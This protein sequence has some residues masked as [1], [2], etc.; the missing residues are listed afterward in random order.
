VVRGSYCSAWHADSC[1]RAMARCVQ[2]NCTSLFF[3]S[4]GFVEMTLPAVLGACSRGLV[5]HLNVGRCVQVRVSS[6]KL[7]TVVYVLQQQQP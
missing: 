7:K 6:D 5:I 2:V 1:G 3:M 4:A